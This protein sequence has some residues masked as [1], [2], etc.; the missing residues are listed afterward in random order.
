MK[1]EPSA[2]GQSIKVTAIVAAIV[3][4]ASVSGY[5]MGLNSNAS[6][7]SLTRSVETR[8][9]E[10][11]MRA[12]APEAGVKTAVR[13]SEVDRSKDG[14]NA[15][16]RNVM[17]N[18]KSTPAVPQP[19]GKV[20]EAEREAAILARMQ[21]RAFDGAPPVVPHPIT[22]DSVAACLS[23]HEQGLQIRERAATRISHAHFTNCTQCHVPSQGTGIPVNDASL[24]KPLTANTFTGAAPVKGRRA[25]PAA[26]P[27]IPHG[28]TMRAD[29]AS[30]HGPAGL[31]GLRTLHPE[32]QACTQCH[33]PEPETEQ[34][35]FSAL[36]LIG[37]PA[38][39]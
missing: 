24:L 31:Y 39:P 36:P 11:A 25:W 4:T 17:A 32:R 34:R 15:G 14:P 9:P 5:F 26:P 6:R 22:E 3:A 8:N 33:V 19:P 28:A 30:C 23:C 27:T 38:Q 1:P 20:S 29:C 16:W 35:P 13:Y 10:A 21:R 37:S 2:R 7:I 18:L 12:A